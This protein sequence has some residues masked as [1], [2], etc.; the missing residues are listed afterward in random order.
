MYWSYRI[1]VLYRDPYQSALSNH[2]RTSSSWLHLFQL[3]QLRSCAG[4]RVF[5]FSFY[6]MVCMTTADAMCLIHH[7]K[8]YAHVLA[9]G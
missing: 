3:R 6:L 9:A 5:L 4:L 1:A 7:I 2:G 8:C